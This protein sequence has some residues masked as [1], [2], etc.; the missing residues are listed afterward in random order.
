MA[1]RYL[2]DDCQLVAATSHCQLRSS[3]NF[4]AAQVHVLMIVLP[5]NSLSILDSFYRELKTC[6]IVLGTSI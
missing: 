6:L 5:G 2:L 4:S 3:Y 1:P